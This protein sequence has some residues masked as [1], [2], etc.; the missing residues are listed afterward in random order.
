LLFLFCFFFQHWE[1]NPEPCT[2]QVCS[3]PLNYRPN[4]FSLVIFICN[5]AI[6]HKAILAF[7]DSK[8][9][10]KNQK[11]KTCTWS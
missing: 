6:M 7:L 1:L 11:K 4:P 8:D 5:S 2:C 10:H 9:L 3:L